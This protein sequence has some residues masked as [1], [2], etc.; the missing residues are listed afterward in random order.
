MNL[1]QSIELLAPAKNAEAGK[2][3]INY[4]ADAVYIGAE[5]FGARAKAGNSVQE[6][7]KLI[8]YAHLFKAK[9][10]ITLNT[11]LFDDEIERAITLAHQVYEAGADALIIQ[12]LGLLE[13][14]LPPLPLFASTQ[15]HNYSLDRIQFLENVGFSRIIL[16][17]ELSLSEIQHIRENTR[18]IELE[19]FVHGALC[20]ALSGQCYLSAASSKRSGNRGD[21]SQ[22]CR[23][24]YTLKDAEGRSIQTNKHLLS[25]KDINLS[26]HLEPLIQAGIN[27]FKIEGR[28][29]DLDY[30]QNNVAYYRKKLDQILSH[31]PQLQKN[32][33]GSTQF[34]F[35]PNPDYS[36]S[37]GFTTYFHEG[38]K[39]NLAS[40][41][42]PKSVGEPLGRIA[43][44]EKNYFTLETPHPFQNGDGITFLSPKGAF[45]GTSVNKT[46]GNKIFPNSMQDIEK[47]CQVSRNYNKAFQE[48]LAKDTSQRLI[49][50][51]IEIRES[52]KGFLLKALDE[53]GIE[54]E[55]EFENPKAMAQQAEL[56]LANIEKQLMKSGGTHF[57][58]SKIRQ[59]LK[60]AYFLPVSTLNEMRRTL[61]NHHTSVRLSQYVRNLKPLE[62]NTIPYPKSQIDF[63][64]NILNSK[65]SAFYKRHGVKQLENGF[66]LNSSPSDDIIFT[67]RYC[68]KFELGSCPKQK[69]QA[70]EFPEPWVLSDQTHHYILSFDCKACLMHLHKG[71]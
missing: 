19:T 25:L 43:S 40:M 16:A 64:G 71:K 44:V 60:S 63:R 23:L 41:H 50:V 36:F 55:W 62:K 17:R 70:Q 11:L 69:N 33:S 6:I 48:V 68:L 38:R 37:R 5:H 57:K 53:D 29:K 52:T 67:S 65:A 9:V 8:Q 42:T 49:S 21:C 14:E 1:P 34:Q 24:P 45:W 32:S 51:E 15:T 58:V 12:D 54:S 46:E 31:N 7:E 39:E 30:I 56:A 4:G 10:Y 66:E 27:S 13:G 3:A 20:T 26:G 35:E 28:M 47:G 22:L 61:L 18:G 2:A 59:E